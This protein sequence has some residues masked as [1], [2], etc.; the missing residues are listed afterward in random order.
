MPIESSSWT[1]L[2]ESSCL[3]VVEQATPAAKSRGALRGIRQRRQL[4]RLP[5]RLLRPSR[6]TPRFLNV[7]KKSVHCPPTSGRTLQTK[8]R[9]P[10][11]PLL[12]P[13][14]GACR[15]VR[16]RLFRTLRRRLECSWHFVYESQSEVESKRLQNKNE[17][18]NRGKFCRVLKLKSNEIAI[19]ATVSVRNPRTKK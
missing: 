6:P 4:G 17:D 13:G 7:S 2:V 19:E 10:T 15:L 12:R 9:V 16:P 1:I 5:C 11:H 14:R 8:M 18:Q 3:E